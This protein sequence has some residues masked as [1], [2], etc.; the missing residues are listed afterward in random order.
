[1]RRSLRSLPLML[2]ATAITSAAQTAPTGMSAPTDQVV[3]VAPAEGATVI[4]GTLRLVWRSVTFG[5]QYEI[6]LSTDNFATVGGTLGALD[7][8]L[9][10]PFLAEYRRYW[11]RVRAEG[12][13]GWGPFSEPR[14]FF[15][16][17][18]ADVP[19]LADAVDRMRV[20]ISP[21]P[22]SDRA[23][24]GLYLPAPASGSIELVD[25]LGRRV[26]LVARGDFEAGDHTIPIVTAGLAPGAY[27]CRIVA[28]GRRATMP[29]TVR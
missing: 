3:L 10:V 23:E 8:T 15:Y 22:A 13:D 29:L 20:G 9:S 4:E 26:A 24:L 21:N 16:Q 19:R 6:Q 12:F 28:D 11:W 1:M 5:T 17:G 18:I 7:T 2:L 25:L 14:S 27:L